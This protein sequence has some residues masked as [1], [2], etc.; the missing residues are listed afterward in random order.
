[1]RVKHMYAT[2]TNEHVYKELPDNEVPY[3]VT[4][5]TK[6]LDQTQKLKSKISYELLYYTN[7]S[8]R[9]WDEFVIE[10]SHTS[11]SGSTYL[12][13]DC[14]FNKKGD[15]IAASQCGPNRREWQEIS[16]SRFIQD[17]TE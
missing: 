17:W 7:T 6:V 1:M 16:F 8:N 5:V 13:A 12:M 9:A 4:V 11:K 10:V 14:T 2:E 3:L 15:F